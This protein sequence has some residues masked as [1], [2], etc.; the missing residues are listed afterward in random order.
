MKT[1]LDTQDSPRKRGVRPNGICPTTDG[2]IW[3]KKTVRRRGL[4]R[5][6]H[7]GPKVITMAMGNYS[8]R[9][10]L[11]P[12]VT[13][14]IA[15]GNNDRQAKHA[16]CQPPV[17]SSPIPSFALA[18]MRRSHGRPVAGPSRHP[19]TVFNCFFFFPPLPLHSFFFFFRASASILGS[20]VCSPSPSLMRA[21]QKCKCYYMKLPL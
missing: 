7:G 5:A 18:D 3:L 15:L 16:L 9:R 6:I 2:P 13:G 8:R 1:H 10:S 17:T 21:A 20:L 14:L 12:A 4:L 19:A 11:H